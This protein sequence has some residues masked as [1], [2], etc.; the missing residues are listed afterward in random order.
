MTTTT[1]SSLWILACSFMVATLV[2]FATNHHERFHYR[3]F[4]TA[5][6]WGYEILSGRTVII[7]QQEIPAFP[8]AKGF[9]KKSHAEAIAQLV[10][11]KIKNG[12]PPS[13]GIFELSG[14]IPEKDLENE[15]KGKQHQ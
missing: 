3:T 7:H 10:I 12:Q 5:N 4:H 9:V 11:K 8:A 6:G 15:S 1:N 2:F 13:V 14:I